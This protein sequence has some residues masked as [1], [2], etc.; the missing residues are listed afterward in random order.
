VAFIGNVSQTADGNGNKH[1]KARTHAR[2][3]I[4]TVRFNQ[5]GYTSCQEKWAVAQG[6][7]RSKQ[8]CIPQPPL[9]SATFEAEAKE[10][11]FD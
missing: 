6:Q 3:S 8:V 1:I 10:M 2:V 4:L 5:H 11:H 7:T 9:P